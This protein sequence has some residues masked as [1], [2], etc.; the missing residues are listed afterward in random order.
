MGAA[1]GGSTAGGGS[2]R[3]QQATDRLPTAI[4]SYSLSAVSSAMPVDEAENS[5]ATP[6]ECNIG[7][8]PDALLSRILGQLSQADR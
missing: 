2:R 4:H 8:L 5:A 6:A 1:T 7:S 3:R